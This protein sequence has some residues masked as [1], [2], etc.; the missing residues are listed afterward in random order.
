[1]QG[2][3]QHPR[4]DRGSEPDPHA[5]GEEGHAVA[6]ERAGQHDALEGD[7]HHAGALAHHASHR[8]QYQRRRSDERDA[9]KADGVELAEEVGHVTGAST[10]RWAMCTVS[11]GALRT[12]NSQ[13]TM[14][15]AA[16]KLI[17][18]AWR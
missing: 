1:M 13:P 15:G 10:S 12:R 6:D 5:V 3:D 4:D 7:V 18:A 17:T 2:G 16:T 9:Q 14:T 8:G 11:A